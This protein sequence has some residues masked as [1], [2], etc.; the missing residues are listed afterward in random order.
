METTGTLDKRNTPRN[1]P[2][3]GWWTEPRWRGG[4]P[5][6][7]SAQRARAIAEK[8]AWSALELPLGRCI[9]G[10]ELAAVCGTS[11][12]PVTWE[13][14]AP[15]IPSAVAPTLREPH[16]RALVGLAR[17]MVKY[18]VER[19]A[20]LAVVATYDELAPL[21]GRSARQT[22]RVVDELAK[23]HVLETFP[24]FEA[25]GA[26]TS[27]RGNGY[28]LGG[29]VWS[30]LLAG[31]ARARVA[32]HELA[33]DDGQASGLLRINSPVEHVLSECVAAFAATVSVSPAKPATI[34]FR[35]TVPAAAAAPPDLSR[36]KARPGAPPNGSVA[37]AVA[38]EP[39]LVT[40]AREFLELLEKLNGGAS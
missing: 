6:T 9:T 28:Q 33:G 2:P 10:H 39:E 15:G 20:A 22:R 24:T 34:D 23:A 31:I 36:V 4:K 12:L 5:A 32:G 18:T 8:R 21:V 17:A 13:M 25:K 35:A 1:T 14:L 7:F 19:G 16:R 11:E 3:A 30:A 37:A 29:T 27:R 26:V 40:S 38:A